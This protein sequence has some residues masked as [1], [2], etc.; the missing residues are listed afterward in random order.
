MRALRTVMPQPNP[1]AYCCQYMPPLMIDRYRSPC[2]IMHCLKVLRATGA[3]L[4][5]AASIHLHVS[6]SHRRQGWP[7]WHDKRP[8]HDRCELVGVWL[9]TELPLRDGSNG[10]TNTEQADLD[11][12]GRHLLVELGGHLLVDGGAVQRFARRPLGRPD[13]RAKDRVAIFDDHLIFAFS[14]DLQGSCAMRC[15]TPLHWHVELPLC[16]RVHIERRHQ[17]RVLL[18]LVPDTL[19]TAPH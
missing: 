8:A 6:D 10:A 16:G 15:C 18:G 1:W 14:N 11:E 7:R 4:V 5:A 13:R 2:T 3:V 9:R 19:C 12:L 17:M